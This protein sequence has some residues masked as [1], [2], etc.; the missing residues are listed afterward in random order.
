[1]TGTE[2]GRCVERLPDRRLRL[3]ER[4]AWVENLAVGEWRGAA[5]RDVRPKPHGAGVG[6]DFAE[7]AAIPD[8]FPHY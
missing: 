3:Q 1:M 6:G 4:V 8:S 2:L 7:A 5:D